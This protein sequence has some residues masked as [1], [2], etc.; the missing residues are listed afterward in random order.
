MA[1]TWADLAGTWHLVEMD[2]APYPAQ[3]VLDIGAEGPI[4]GRAPCNSFGFVQDAPF[5]AFQAGAIRASRM[6]CPD[7]P[8]EAAF[9]ETLRAVTHA[10]RDGDR[11]ILKSAAGPSLVFAPEGK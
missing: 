9:F 6:A 7:L 10:Q 2:G 8:L 3:T 1:D 5:P 4:R 11:L